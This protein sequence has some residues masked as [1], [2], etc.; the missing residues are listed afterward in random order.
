VNP[1]EQIIRQRFQEYYLAHGKNF[2]VP[3]SPEE[4]EYGFLLFKEK[5][6]VRHRAFKDSTQLLNAIRDLVPAHVYF[7]TAYYHDPTASMDEKGWERADLVFDIDAD[8]LDTPCKSRHDTWK[9]KGCGNTGK[10]GAPKICSK[11]KN[12]RMEEQT[13]LCGQCLQQAKEETTKLLEILYSDLGVNPSDTHIFFSGH[14]GYHVHVYSKDLGIFAEEERRE[15]ASYVLGQGL[16]PE[17][18][19]LEEL[20]TGGTTIIEGP[21][22]GQP[23]WRGRMVAGIHD[24]LGEEAEQLGLSR[25]QNK[26]L[27][28]QDPQTFFRKPFWSSVKGVGLSTWKTLSSRAV[29]KRSAKIDTVVTTDIHRLI[30][31]PGTLNGHTGL[32]AM[33][34][35]RERLEDFDPFNEALA[36]QGTMKIRVKDCP[37]FV[38]D[39]KEFGPYQNEEVELPSYAAMLLLCKRRA[40]PPGLTAKPLNE[41]K[42]SIGQEKA[43]G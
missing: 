43:P 12:D 4:R 2:Y 32:L 31:L 34:V 9:C 1:T 20:S 16:E 23:G 27:M 14:R 21:Q 38:L 10:G 7:S 37:N 36:F 33:K 19:E 18:H 11:C 17:L 39:K 13:W 24:V 22:L 35:Q 25:T 41:P 15:I 30:R 28:D 6:M 29:E 40:E 8:H 5:F 3:P 26:I 42:P